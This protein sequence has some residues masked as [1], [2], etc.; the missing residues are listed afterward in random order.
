MLSKEAIEGMKKDGYTFEQIESIKKWLK[1]IEEWKT[2]S[3]EVFWSRVHEKINSK[4][5]EHV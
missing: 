5:K 4:M 3:E 2:I 1:N